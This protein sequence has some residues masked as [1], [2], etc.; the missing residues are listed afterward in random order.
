VVVRFSIVSN[1]FDKCNSF[2]SNNKSNQVKN[3][4]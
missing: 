1:D 4:H 3:L 2:V